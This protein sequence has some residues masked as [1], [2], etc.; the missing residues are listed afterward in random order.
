MI[1]IVRLVVVL[2]IS[3]VLLAAAGASAPDARVA[4][5]VEAV[6]PALPFPGSDDSGTVPNG[7]GDDAK[8]FVVWP[9]EPDDTRVI[10]RAN[11]LHPDTQKLV[12]SAEGAIQRAVAVAER[13]AQAAYDRALDELKRTGKAA[14][15]DGISLD[16]EGAAGQRL[17]AELELTIELIEPATFQIASSVE[18]TVT[19]GTNGVTW[20]VMVPANAVTEGSGAERRERFTASQARLLFGAIPRP[21]VNRVDGQPRYAVTMSAAPGAFAVVV[22]GNDALLKQ[23]LAGADWTRLASVK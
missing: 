19:A 16:D 11:P 22:R 23:V 7:G 2:L 5:M 15:L 18:P 20:Q 21:H 3:P 9:A 8:W 14:D 10:V 6:R 13:K 17:D 12:S 4:A 1:G